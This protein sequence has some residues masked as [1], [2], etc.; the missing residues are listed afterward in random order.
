MSK[1]VF[2][3]LD[4]LLEHADSKFS[5]VNIVTK[6]ARQ[7]N[8]WIRVQQLPATDRREYFA[9]EP[10]VD[11]E[12]INPNKPVSIALDEIADGK[13]EYRRTREGIK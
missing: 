4:V 3:D 12:T 5:L 9:S 8:N 7:L 2:G 6:R 1:S 10:L 11:P 13:I